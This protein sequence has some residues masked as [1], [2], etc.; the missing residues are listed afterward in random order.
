MSHQLCRFLASL[1]ILFSAAC[2][3]RAQLTPIVHE[4]APLTDD[5]RAVAGS[6]NQFA[7]DIFRELSAAKAGQNVLVSPLSIS[8]ALAMTYTG[9][10]GETA[11]QMADALHF[12]LPDDR[13]HA[14]FGDL[15]AD[16]GAERQGYELSIAN[17]LFGQ[18]A[19]GFKPPFLQTLSGDYAAPLEAL[20]FES[21]PDDAR[22]HINN[23]VSERTQDR[24]L[25]LLPQGSIDNATR[26][27]L[28]NAI[29]FNGEWKSKFKKE[30]TR[31]APFY[32]TG[33]S[34]TQ[35]SLMYQKEEFH[36]G[37]FGDVQILEMP[38]VG[39]DVSM[40]VLLPDAV[41]GLPALEASLS[42]ESLD[43][44]LAALQET[45]VEVYL[46]KFT[47]KSEFELPDALQT[48][49]ITDLFVPGVADLT[50]MADAELYVTRAIH[51]TFIDVNEEG[52]EAAAATGITIGVTSV[53]PPPPVFRADHPFLFALRD[54]HTGSLMFLGRVMETDSIAPLAAPTVPEPASWLLMMIGARAFLRKRTQR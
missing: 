44:Q 4:R 21:M 20:D 27:V 46:P 14:A 53:P 39:G 2:V 35:A 5:V 15:L 52:T 6:N 17:R 1:A 34:Q 13:L 50:G 30:A 29:Y 12:T 37:R 26:L 42:A 54:R 8:T 33:N 16:L 41:N 28:T 45:E 40:V 7:V 18:Q 49:G 3:A 19:F 32:L 47:F 22:V 25:D 10:R 11:R 23:W 43:T 38:Y 31:E 9:A 48:L 24:I 51:K 36:Y